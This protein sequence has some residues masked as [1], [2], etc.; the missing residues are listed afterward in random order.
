MRK[1]EETAVVPRP[2]R[3]IWT[4]AL[5]AGLLFLA[6]RA[7]D[8]VLGWAGNAQE[9]RTTLWS[10]GGPKETAVFRDGLRDGPCERFHPDGTLR[11]RG[12]FAAGRMEG[13]WS[14]F[15]ASGALDTERSGTYAANRRVGPLGSGLEVGLARYGSA[16]E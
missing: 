10:A 13:E 1:I 8:T 16:S 4:F 7:A 2:M 9:T 6:F 11:A 14:F 12:L 3:K 15:D 5:F